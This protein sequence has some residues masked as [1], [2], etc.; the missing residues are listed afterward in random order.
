MPFSYKNFTGS[1]ALGNA[2]KKKEE[3]SADY[4][5]SDDVSALYKDWQAKQATKPAQWTGGQYGADVNKALDD[6]IN[7]KAFNYDFNGDALY[8]QYKDMYMRQ[9]KLAMADTMGQ[10]AALN[11]GYGTSYATSAGQQTYNGYMQQL[12][13]VLPELYQLA[14]QKYQAEGDELTNRYGLL[15]NQYD[16][17]YG[18][19]RNAVS[20]WNSDVERAYNIY[21]NERANEQSQYAANR[22]Y[23]SNN[24]NNLYNQE[25]GAYS[26]AYDRA[27]ALYQ[28]QV[29][30]Q[31]AK[32]QLDYQYAQLRLQ[33]DK[34]DYEKDNSGSKEK[35]VKLD[36]GTEVPESVVTKAKKFT[37]NDDLYMY[38]GD[39]VSDG[40]ITEAQGEELYGKYA[41][42]KNLSKSKSKYAYGTG[43]D[44][45]YNLYTLSQYPWK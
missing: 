28:Q 32:D 12:N 17:E 27:F 15:K 41:I 30:E 40:T 3:Y 29:A 23:A 8:Q 26:D 43:K 21:N 5:E 25:Y 7:R 1:A 24:Y 16:T 20:D 14:L 6:I 2:A 10:A 18:E 37:N 36:S 33:Q 19:Y 39:M 34:F 38:L 31:Q 22:E 42:T 13:N 4:R 9:G 35:T 44:G 45:G 11:G